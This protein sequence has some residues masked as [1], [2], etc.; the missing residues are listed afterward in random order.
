MTEWT[1][2]SRIVP[3][4]VLAGRYRVDE[5]VWMEFEKATWRGV[6]TELGRTVGVRVARFRSGGYSAID[7][8]RAQFELLSAIDHPGVM[9][10]Y[11]VGSDPAADAYLITEHIEPSSLVREGPMRPEHAM[12]VVAQAA[13]ALAAVHDSGVVYRNVKRGMIRRSDGTI[14]LFDF[15]R[16]RRAGSPDLGS[17]DA[18]TD[19]YELGEWVY[20]WLTGRRRRQP[21]P[22][23]PYES[24][25]WERP[26]GQKGQPPPPFV[27]I[28]VQSVVDRM[29]ALEVKDR[30][31]TASA[32][33]DAARSALA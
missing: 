33:A 1:P 12:D 19:I 5:W 14:V 29:L 30:W 28:G 26:R 8:F 15:H 11:A 18:L 27:P 10:V 25:S 32:L 31:P 6:D 16:A 4:T 22:F 21:D 23:H 17:R 3:G 13:D 20:F 24:P 9:R 2:P 7:S